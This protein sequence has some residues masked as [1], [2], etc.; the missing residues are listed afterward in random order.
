MTNPKDSRANVVVDARSWQGELDALWN[1]IGYD[2]INYTTTPEGKKTL[3]KF[4]DFAARPYHVRAHHLLCNGNCRSTPKWGSTNVYIEDK[5]GAPI[6][7]FEVIDDIFD[8][9]LDYN[10]KPFVELGF[11]PYDLADTGGEYSYGDYRHGGWAYPPKDY[12]RWYDLI[13]KLVEHCKNR[14]GR[15]EVTS[16]YWELWNEPDLDFYWQGSIEEYCKLYDYTAAAFK[17][18][19]PEGKIGGPATTGPTEGSQSARW[20]DEFLKHCLKGKNYYNGQTGSPLDYVSFHAK[21][22][23]FPKAIRPEDDLTSVKRLLSQIEYGLEIIG[24]YPELEGIYVNLS[25]CDPDGWAA[26]GV[27]DNP[28]LNF[29]NTEYYPSYV[30]TAFKNL[31]DIAREYPG[32]IDALT[33]AFMFVGERCFEGTRSFTTR[34][35]EKPILNL[36][37]MFAKLGHKRLE[38][39]SSRSQNPREYADDYGLQEDP[40]I[41][42][43]ASVSGDNKVQILLFCHHDDW[44]REGNYEINLEVK[45]LPFK[46]EKAKLTHYRL[47]ADHSNAYREWLRQD[48]PDYP[49]RAQKEAIKRREGLEL[50]EPETKV[51]L[52]DGKFK[53]TITLPVHGISMLIIE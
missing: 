44:T 31:L 24:K 36:F 13:Y 46:K 4:Q 5:Q 10:L 26:G 43:L 3:Q 47:D 20:L 19:L 30:L 32:D 38:L 37:K 1:F 8:T 49:S 12:D 28:Q 15:R 25:E 42:G 40:L 18:V 2:E 35:I 9:Y 33:W 41:D 51:K 34:G 29:R 16:W 17:E 53:K 11:M 23:G 52:L 39:S 14:Y 21:G 48:A 27:G 45:N 22:G 7:N 50:L 6:Y